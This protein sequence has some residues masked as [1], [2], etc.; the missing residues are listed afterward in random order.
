MNVKAMSP[1]GQNTRSTGGTG[2]DGT[3]VLTLVQETAKYG[4][5]HTRMNVKNTSTQ[6]DEP[7]MWRMSSLLH[8]VSEQ[9]TFPVPY[10][11]NINQHFLF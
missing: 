5:E 8:F 11:F 9:Q 3:K 2:I 7:I 1:I 6:D 10:K 4:V